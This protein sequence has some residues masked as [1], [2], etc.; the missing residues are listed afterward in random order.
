M[1][2][3][4]RTIVPSLANVRD[5]VIIAKLSTT[6]IGDL[7]IDQFC[8]LLR[9]DGKSDEENGIIN[10]RRALIQVYFD[11]ADARRQAKATRDQIE[12]ARKALESLTEAMRKLDLVEPARQ[13]GLQA[14]F[15]SPS[16]DT[17]GLDEFNEFGSRCSDVK[18]KVVPIAQALSQL[19]EAE[20]TKPK[21]AKSG[22]RK[23]RLRTLVE[24]LAVWWRSE[25]GK[26][27]SPYVHAKRLDHRPALVVG[28]RGPFI[29]LAQAL[30]C[31]IDEF[32]ESEVISA[33][34]NVHEIQ[35]PTAKRKK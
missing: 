24:G 20:V 10:L 28:R 1:I 26:S 8:C 16:D 32:S 25:T 15:G 7:P 4:R 23:K 21:P 13:R 34:T 31:K 18:I 9:N 22:E 30:F 3:G 5:N 6:T 2:V 33:V 19:I 17:K 12:S 29:D 27:L 11:A 35:L 14:V